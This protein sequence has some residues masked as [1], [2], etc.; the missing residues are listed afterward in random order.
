MKMFFRVIVISLLPCQINQQACLLFTAAFR[1]M[2]VFSPPGSQS[3]GVPIE[4]N[5]NPSPYRD[6]YSVMHRNATGFSGPSQSQW[7]EYRGGTSSSPPF[8]SSTSRSRTVGVRYPVENSQRQQSNPGEVGAFMPQGS[9]GLGFPLQV[10]AATT[11]LPHPQ[12][13][14]SAGLPHP[15]GMTSMGVP[16]LMAMPS[17]SNVF[18]GS[19]PTTY[20]GLPLM[21]PRLRSLVGPGGMGGYSGNL[22]QYGSQLLRG[23]V[24]RPAITSVLQFK[25]PQSANARNPADFVP[26]VILSSDDGRLLKFL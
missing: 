9:Y 25:T 16:H 22:G 23:H 2:S 19:P 8:S 4:Q 13:V 7:I 3:H 17:A 6:H 26:E 21:P 18:P 5:L 14:A 24:L 11:A 20:G 10:T 12:T 1:S 15:L